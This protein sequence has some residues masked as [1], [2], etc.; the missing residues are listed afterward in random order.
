MQG[1]ERDNGAPQVQGLKGILGDRDLICLLVYGAGAEADGMGGIID[2]QR[3]E[4]AHCLRRAVFPAG[5]PFLFPVHTD[6]AVAVVPGT[7]TAA[8][9]GHV[10]HKEAYGRPLEGVPIN[11]GEDAPEGIVG[12]N[13]VLQAQELPQPPLLL[14]PKL[15]NL[16]P[17][18]SVC[19]HGKERDEEDLRQGIVRHGVD[20]A[21]LH[22]AEHP[23]KPADDGFWGPCI[24]RDPCL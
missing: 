4:V 5:P 14:F 11:K 16:G 19:K 2:M 17:C 20:P 18:G 23:D 12:R 22:A 6:Q 9:C 15:G 10:L 21:V 1:I 13:S 3:L 24:S 7:H 8:E